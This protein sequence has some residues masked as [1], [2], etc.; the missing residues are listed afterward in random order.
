M[1][2]VMLALTA[3]VC[4]AWPIPTALAA[5]KPIDAKKVSL[6][7]P[8]DPTGAGR[9][10][11]LISRAPNIEFGSD[12]DSDSPKDHGAS[13]LVFN[14]GTSECQCIQVP[15]GDRWT[16]G[17]DGSRYTYRDVGVV[18][19]SVKQVVMRAGKLK[20]AAKGAGLTG[21]TLNESEQGQMAVHYTSGTANKLCAYFPGMTVRADRPTVF[22]AGDAP[23]PAACQPEPAACSPCV[24]PALP[25]PTTTTTLP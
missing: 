2:Q 21:V 1:K 3:L 7:D 15:P 14:P 24:P 25:P 18:D 5:D 10:F 22:V 23:T 8:N 20:I 16:L 13:L 11:L 17:P 9:R 19:T 6:R 12:K 4:A